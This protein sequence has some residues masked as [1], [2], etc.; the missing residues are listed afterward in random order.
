MDHTGRAPFAPGTGAYSYYP[1][2]GWG[3]PR[4][5]RLGVLFVSLAL[6]RS[7]S[8]LGNHGCSKIWV[9]R[10]AGDV[11]REGLEL[12]AGSRSYAITWDQQDRSAMRGRSDGTGEE[13]G[14]GDG[15]AERELVLVIG[16]EE[17]ETRGW[18]DEEDADVRG[19]KD[20][21]T[22]KDGGQARG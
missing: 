7:S 9:F 20:S 16:E 3:Y 5:M 13:R 18:M 1:L 8:R 11:V 21:G 22:V 6:S 2:D 14:I 10:N 19:G 4:I 15:I 12:I 17:C